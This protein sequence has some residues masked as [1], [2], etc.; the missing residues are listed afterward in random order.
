M[1]SGKSLAS[2][3]KQTYVIANFKFPF[4]RFAVDPSDLIPNPDFVKAVQQA[5]DHNNSAAQTVA[6]AKVF[7]RWGH[8]IAVCVLSCFS[9][10]AQFPFC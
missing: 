4:V 10:T 2:T 5:L 3:T 6:L 1:S 7:K 9:N 8:V